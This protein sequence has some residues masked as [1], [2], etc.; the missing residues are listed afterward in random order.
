MIS[1]SETN[2]TENKKGEGGPREAIWIYDT[3]ILPE[4]C[5]SEAWGSWKLVYEMM[6]RQALSL[7]VKVSRKKTRKKG[8]VALDR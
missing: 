8:E 5:L 7:R 1:Q 4:R 3:P 6:M 2:P